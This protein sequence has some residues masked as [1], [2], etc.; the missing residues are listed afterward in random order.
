MA[1]D[2]PGAKGGAPQRVMSQTSAMLS[3]VEQQKSVFKELLESEDI[4]WEV[5]GVYVRMRFAGGGR[6]S[7]EEEP[8]SDFAGL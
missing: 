5:D 2:V 1:A 6:A 7:G 8:A 4:G 3:P